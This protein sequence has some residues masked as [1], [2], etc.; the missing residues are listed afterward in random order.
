MIFSNVDCVSFYVEN[1]DDGITFYSKLLGLKLL[2]R[3]SNSCGLGLENDIT[4]VVLVTEHNPVVQFKVDS[5]ESALDR[6]L[7]AGGTLVYG[8]FDIDIGKCAVVK[9]KWENQFCILDMSKGKYTV[10]NNGNV[11]GVM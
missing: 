1:L 10:D 3:A 8:P 4:E 7:K 2:W 11:T 6:F 5:V 9:D